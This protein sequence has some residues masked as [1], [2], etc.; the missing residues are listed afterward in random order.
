MLWSKTSIQSHWVH[1]EAAEGRDR[2]CL[3][4]LSLDGCDPPLGFRQFQTIDVSRS[5]RRPGS[6]EMRRLVAAASVEEP[7]MLELPAPW[8]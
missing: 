7:T 5:K 2:R 1:D 3:V 8:R 6:P 4:P